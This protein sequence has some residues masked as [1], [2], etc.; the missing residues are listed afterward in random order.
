MKKI[1][2]LF[3]FAMCINSYAQNHYS[4]S[5]S[6]EGG[7]YEIIQSSTL[8]SLLFKLDKETGRIYQYAKNK[9]GDN[10][11]EEIFVLGLVQDSTVAV[12]GKINYQL[13]MSGFSVQEIFLLNI[14][15]GHTFQLLQDTETNKL[16]FSHIVEPAGNL[17]PREIDYVREY[18]NRK[19]K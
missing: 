9:N 6:V 14:N 4:N 5:T 18:F 1:C 11:W 13:F 15:N 12:P 10:N 3:M 2:I 7:R 8:N 17:F 19:E 16:F